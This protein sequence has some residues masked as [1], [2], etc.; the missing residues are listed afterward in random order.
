MILKLFKIFS[1]NL[2]SF[3]NFFGSFKKG[4]KGIAK[5]FE[6]DIKEETSESKT[7]ETK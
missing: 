3:E 2:F 4:A 7:E 1:S 6:E 5:E